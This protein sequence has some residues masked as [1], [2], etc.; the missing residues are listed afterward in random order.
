MYLGEMAEVDQIELA[1]TFLLLRCIELVI[2][3]SG[4]GGRIK[5]TIDLKVLVQRKDAKK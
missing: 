5:C 2:V 4:E 1:A 3:R